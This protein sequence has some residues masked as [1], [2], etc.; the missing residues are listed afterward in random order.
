MMTRLLPREEWDRLLDTEA[1]PACPYFPEDTRVIVVEAHGDV[2]G[3]WSMPRYLHAECLTINATHRR[4]GAVGRLLLNAMYEQA[5]ATG[6]RVVLTSSLD[7]KIDQ[8]CERV[9][10]ARLPGAHY[11]IPIR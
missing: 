2:L 3:A 9:G 5:R 8:W 10:G 7:S 1:G 6:D 4:K 11:V